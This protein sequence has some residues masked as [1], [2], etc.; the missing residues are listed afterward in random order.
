[1]N[2]LLKYLRLLLPALLVPVLAPADPTP[3]RADGFIPSDFLQPAAPRP[4]VLLLGVFHFDDAGLDS[5]QPKHRLDIPSA[6]FQRQL[7]EV[8]GQLKAF[9]P[10]KVA[11]EA[12]AGFQPSAN[13]RLRQFLDGK[14]P[15]ATRPN[16]VYQLGFRLVQAAGLD[17]IFC[18]DVQGQ[19]LAGV[20]DT[21]DKA[22]AYAR[23]HHEEGL[24]DD[25]WDARFRQLY[26][27]DDELKTQIP[28]RNFLLYLNS[29][30]RLRMGQGA[31]VTGLFKVGAGDKYLGADDL[32]SW[33]D[34]N[35]RIFANILRLA[36]SPNERVV[37]ILGAGHMPILRQLAQ[38][39]PELDLVEVRDVLGA[40]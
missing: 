3:Q 15:L 34:R 19:T 18:I 33:Y 24:I 12:E 14:L 4:H 13:E 20:P 23:S 8:V 30:E 27:F 21:M 40:P 29:P 36:D 37:V 10:T 5:Y 31:Y 25:G 22:R 32:A 6:A 1:V 16:E 38:A 39:S 35:L 28:L 7:A 11:I 9:H 17:R 26:E 2:S